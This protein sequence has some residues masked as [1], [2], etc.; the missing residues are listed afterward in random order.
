MA[1]RRSGF[2]G[3]RGVRHE[4]ITVSRQGD[5]YPSIRDA[6]AA[7]PDNAVIM[8]GPGRYAEQLVLTKTVEIIPV[9]GP[10]SVR[11][12]CA[13]GAPVVLAA[14]YAALTGLLIEAADG[15]SPAVVVAMGKLRVSD[16][17]LTA[18]AWAAAVACEHGTLLLR[19]STVRNADG[20]GVVI[21]SAATGQLEHCHLT[22][23][24]GSAAVAGD[25][26]VLSVRSC[27]LRAVGGRGLAVTGQA[28]LSVTDSTITD[29]TGTAV[30][31]EQQA[32]A[33]L[34]RVRITGAEAV[35]FQLSSAG[36]VL[37][38][39]CAVHGSG[40]EGVL[41]TGTCA[42]VL[43]Q[44]QVVDAR[45]SGLRF[46]ER[47]AGE[48]ADC[49]IRRAHGDGIHIGPAAE[50][51]LSGCRVTD[52]AAH[53]CQFGPGAS[54]AV[55][56]SEFV[57][58]A[59]D[60]IRVHAPDAVRID[61]CVTSGNGGEGRR[62]RP[63]APETC[64][65]NGQPV[66]AM[67][68]PLRQLLGL[69]GLGG[70]KREIV[71]L[72]NLARM[73]RRRQ[74]AGLSAP[75]MARHL[76]FAG[77]PGTGKSTVA[78]LYGEI[79]AELGV[80]NCGRLVE[81]TAADLVGPTAADTVNRTTEVVTGALGGVLYL[82]DPQPL[83]TGGDRERAAIRTLSGL[84]TEH[85]Q[86]LVVIA[87]GPPAGLRA[88]LAAHPVLAAKF[89]RAVEFDDY[90]PEELVTIFQSHCR[91]HDYRVDEAATAA[92]LSY[93][94]RIPADGRL[95]N[96]RAARRIFERMADRQAS[97][98]AARAGVTTGEL[99]LLTLEDFVGRGV[100]VDGVESL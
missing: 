58:N 89:N 83:G 86:E 29:V 90:T 63:D 30:A 14:E 53:G 54:G 51:S 91:Q 12:T 40:A 7:A 64:G 46:T 4:V 87:A 77:A 19:S 94:G 17:E 35:G 39:E 32:T 76:V 52:G 66:S 81:A 22:G 5:G 26:G 82:L 24:G 65:P 23:I 44:C 45:G 11:L 10:G 93:F 70:V 49:S 56:D 16:C 9:D 21:T 47:A 43:R 13:D 55:A 38:D 84:L 34:A 2:G 36:A 98:L 59:G 97:R 85:G 75:P 71:S 50:V 41:V 18:S 80:L 100:S 20:D 73:A 3:R 31:I 95:R 1:G 79:L 8:V 33:A 28:R 15:R 99:T 92:L 67:P 62:L 78:R 27:A 69:V 6:V 88:F 72:I 48:L 42:P 96:G 57:G 60:G 68:D 37:L 61:R 25:T 74:A